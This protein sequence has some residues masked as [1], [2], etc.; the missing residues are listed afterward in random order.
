MNII[1]LID[2]NGDVIE[3]GDI[4]QRINLADNRSTYYLYTQASANTKLFLFQI[5][6]NGEIEKNSLYH[7][8][9]DQSTTLCNSNSFRWYR[10]VEEVK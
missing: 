10:V 1:T 4:V 8:P 6:K 5:T 2:Y 3:I 7:I 9:V